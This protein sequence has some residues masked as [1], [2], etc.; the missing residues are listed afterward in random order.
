MMKEEFKNR[1]RNDEELQ[2][3]RRKVYS[4]TGQLKDI[5]FCLGGKYT[6]EEWKEHLRK[7]V[8][9]H[10]GRIDVQNRTDTNG[11][12]VSIL[13]LQLASPENRQVRSA[14]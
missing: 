4:I 1:M 12:K 2:E 10:G 3:L 13:F 9:E 11:A 14:G 8:E 6:L 7:I 5:S